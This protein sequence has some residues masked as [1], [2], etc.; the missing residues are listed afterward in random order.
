MNI[1]YNNLPHLVKLLISI[2][3]GFQLTTRKI[4]GR[5]Y[6]YSHKTITKAFIIMVYFRLDSYRSLSRFLKDHSDFAKACDL[7]HSTPSYRTLSRRLKT[8]DNVLWLF[9]A[10]VIA[11]LLKYRLISLSIIS[12]D[13][14][15]L[16]A[17]GKTTQKDN[18][19]VIPTDKDASWGWSQT[20][21]FVYG[22]KLHL[23]STVLLKKQNSNTNHLENY[24]SQL[25]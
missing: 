6:V 1:F 19:Y 2:V 10:Q 18:P 9:I 13:S 22:Y 21:N 4:F 17:K 3:N 20:K 7:K 5:P 14:S 8:L 15:L 24:Q 11:V 25:P 16:S 12:T 23:T